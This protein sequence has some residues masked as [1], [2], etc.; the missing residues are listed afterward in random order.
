MQLVTSCLL[1]RLRPRRLLIVFKGPTDTSHAL[2]DASVPRESPDAF[3]QRIYLRST[4]NPGDASHMTNFYTFLLLRS[5]KTS[6]VFRCLV[7]SCRSD[8]R[9]AG[10]VTDFSIFLAGIAGGKLVSCCRC[11]LE[12][13]CRKGVTEQG[14]TSCGMSKRL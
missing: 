13:I 14:V 6:H 10:A 9:L 4:G 8:R 12:R 7:A 3:Q 11:D 5:Y 1:P 2:R